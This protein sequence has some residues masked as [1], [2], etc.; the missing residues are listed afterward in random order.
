MRDACR[1]L[2]TSLA[3][4]LAAGAAACVTSEKSRYMR[5]LSA[6]VPQRHAGELPANEPIALGAKSDVHVDAGD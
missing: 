2:R 5:H 4:V 6:V 3:I 1:N